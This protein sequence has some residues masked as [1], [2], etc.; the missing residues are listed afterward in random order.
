[1]HAMQL[2][3]AGP[4]SIRQH[5]YPNRNERR[6][7]MRRT[8]TPD[9]APTFAKSQRGAMIT[10]YYN[11]YILSTDMLILFVS[12][13]SGLGCSLTAIDNLGQIGKSLGY[14]T[15][16][17]S[18]LVS[19]VSIWNYFGRVF[20]GFVSAKLVVKWKVPR[21][22]MMTLSLVLPSIGDLLIAFPFPG[23]VVDH[24]VLVQCSTNPTL[25][26][27]IRALWIELLLDII[28]LRP[29]G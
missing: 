21:T 12:T 1:M 17:I 10:P 15:H 29:T 11:P 16:T 6:P 13:F 9:A 23:S 8:T 20:S 26:H 25:H 5:R 28:Q 7:R 18:T 27:T 22:L 19:L 3:P 4:S 24:R 14:P 2:R